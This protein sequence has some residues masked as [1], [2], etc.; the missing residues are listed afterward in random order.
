MN[1]GFDQDQE[2]LRL[3]IRRFLGDHC[4][5]T[6]TRSKLESSETFDREIWRDT[7]QFG[8][9]GFLASE[10]RGGGSISGQ[11]LID[12]VVVAEEMGR[13]LAPIFLPTSCS[14][15]VALEQGETL[16]QSELLASSI[17][18]ESLVAW[19][20]AGGSL[21][22]Y[23]SVGKCIETFRGDYRINGTATYVEGAGVADYFLVLGHLEEGMI[24]LLVPSSAPGI[25]SRRL[26][27]LDLTRKLFEVHFDDVVV[28]RDATVGVPGVLTD[29]TVQRQMEVAMILQCA[30]SVGAAEI[31][32]DRTAEY[33]KRRVA[34]GRPIASFQAIKHK[35]ADMVLWLETSRAA[36]YYAALAHQEDFGDAQ[37]AARIAKAY[38]G[39]AFVAISCEEIQIHG[40]AAFVWEHDAHLYLRRQKSN[41][42]LLGSPS[43]HRKKLFASLHP[44]ERIV[45]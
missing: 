39:D 33:A 37:E 38:G 32:L 27:T 9:Q 23:Q 25:R 8:W 44:K 1:F 42:V 6:K 17:Q 21:W 14:V 5:L 30:E 26:G 10:E 41:Q 22:N 2:T 24:Q 35:C 20:L 15:N 36:T 11:G 29:A 28:P 43:W 40:G 18:G 4:A 16:E 12:L 34:F 3:G 13:V 31:V 7:A 19:C 45:N